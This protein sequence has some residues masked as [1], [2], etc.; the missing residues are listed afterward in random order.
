[1]RTKRLKSIEQK[2]EEKELLR[3][4]IEER[5][6]ILNGLE[7]QGSHTSSE[8]YKHEKSN[9]ESEQS[10]EDKNDRISKTYRKKLLVKYKSKNQTT[11]ILNE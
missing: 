8:L 11:I 6:R 10:R 1:M 4:R 2:E 9:D 3:S 7:R 5:E